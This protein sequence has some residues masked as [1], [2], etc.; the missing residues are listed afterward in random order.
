[1]ARGE[2]FLRLL[3]NLVNALGA[4][5]KTVIE[6]EPNEHEGEN[7]KHVDSDLGP[8]RA[9]SILRLWRVKSHQ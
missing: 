4:H 3:N 9:M 1:V 8:I 5:N 7:E 2:K 6:G